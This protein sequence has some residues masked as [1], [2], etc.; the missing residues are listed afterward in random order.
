MTESRTRELAV[1]YHVNDLLI[2]HIPGS[3]LL[4]ILD[5]LEHGRPV[6][7]LA[8]GFLRA[9]GLEALQRLVAGGLSLDQFRL[10]GPERGSRALRP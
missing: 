2:A 4:S 5:G 3:R 8:D 7:R 1:R 6:S 10:P 9:L